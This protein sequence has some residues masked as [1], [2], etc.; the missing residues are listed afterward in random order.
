M[1]IQGVPMTMTRTPRQHGQTG[2]SLI[3]VLV[4][5][6][7][8]ALGLLG[9]A[10]LQAYSL[11]A[12]NLA[13]QRSLAAMQA[14]SIIES[15]RANR[16]NLESYRTPTAAPGGSIAEADRA[17]WVAGLAALPGAAGTITLPAAPLPG[18]G[19]SV[20]VTIG[21]AWSETTDAARTVRFNTTT[22]IDL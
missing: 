13:M 9:F 8:I 21:I 5:M 15:M 18:A 10:G 22:E 14:H 16:F 4:S 19:N 1:L 2:F 17:A 3:E 6:V 11:K 7:V 20:V 12:N